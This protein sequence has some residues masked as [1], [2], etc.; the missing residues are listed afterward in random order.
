MCNYATQWAAGTDIAT[1]EN[2]MILVKPKTEQQ[3]GEKTGND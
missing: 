1:A 2:E 3:K